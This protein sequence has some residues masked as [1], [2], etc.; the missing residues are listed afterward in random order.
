MSDI[1]KLFYY[2]DF[3]LCLRKTVGSRTDSEYRILHHGLKILFYIRRFRH[4]HQFP[5]LLS[6]VSSV[7]FRNFF[8]HSSTC[9]GLPLFYVVNHSSKLPLGYAS[10]PFIQYLCTYTSEVR[11]FEGRFIQV[12]PISTTFAALFIH[13]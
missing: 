3:R 1:F 6:V 13:N 2:S 5:G 8:V 10:L 9:I 11:N 12:Q 7:C 4:H